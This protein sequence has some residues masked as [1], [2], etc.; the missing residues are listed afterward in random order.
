MYR[1]FFS[2]IGRGVRHQAFGLYR[3]EAYT[4]PEDSYRSPGALLF[5]KLIIHFAHCNIE[6]NLQE[7]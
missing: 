5:K 2:I 7:R 4:C 6:Q 3:I 1:R